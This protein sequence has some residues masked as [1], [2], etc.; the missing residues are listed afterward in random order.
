[1][2]DGG[3]AHRRLHLLGGE[4]RIAQRVK[5]RAAAQRRPRATGR[6]S[7][8]GWKTRCCAPWPATPGSVS[9]LPKRCCSRWNGG[10]RVPYRH[11][12]ARL[13][14]TAI[15]RRAWQA[16]ALI[17]LVINLLLLYLLLIR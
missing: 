2:H 12:S 4:A 6:M 7:P 5:R 8:S 9:K 3:D 13:S 16:V 15:P 11:R 10:K 17:M 1:M 14:G